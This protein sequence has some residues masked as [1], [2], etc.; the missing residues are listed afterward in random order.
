MS[1]Q[2]LCKNQLRRAKVLSKSILNGIDYLEVSADKKTLL[3]YFLHNLPGI[4][5][6]DSVPANSN[7]LTVDNILIT[8]GTRVRNIVVESVT[9]FENLLTVRVSGNSDFSTYTLRLVDS[10]GITA[11]SCFDSQLSQVDFSFWVED[12]SEFDCNTPDAPAKKKPPPPFID[13]LA[14]DYSSFRRLI[15]DRLAVTV[16]DWQERNPADIGIL[17]V[18]ILAYAAD[19]LSYYQDAVA[20]EA[21]LGTARK[22]VSVRRHA[23][24]LDYFMHDGC[25]AR[26]WVVLEVKSNSQADGCILQGAFNSLKLQEN[27]IKTRFLTKIKLAKIQGEKDD[28]G[29]WIKPEKYEELSFQ[30]PQVFETASRY[31]FICRI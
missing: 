14:K 25:N 21:Y 29:V 17:L 11:A 23:R 13:Y 6:E 24:M 8:G 10:D 7:A 9:S 1:T 20:T 16:P 3:I 5:Q 28:T 31:Y 18:E 27:Q 12:R 19:H 2:Y 26:A 22:R 15:L 4:A 30:Q